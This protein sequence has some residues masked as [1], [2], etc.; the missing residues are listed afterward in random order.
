MLEHAATVRFEHFNYNGDR[1]R[2]EAL[3]NGEIAV[4]SVDFAAARGYIDE[5]RLKA[6]GISTTERDPEGIEA[7]TA[8]GTTV[9]CL[10]RKNYRDYLAYT[11]ADWEDIA[12]GV[13][14][15]RP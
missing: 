11:Y 1:E 8:H 14:L 13:G 5:N 12:I 6:L 3:L 4:G 2:I 7:L 15:Y 10:N 9:K